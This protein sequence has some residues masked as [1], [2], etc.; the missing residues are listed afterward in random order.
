[1]ISL[2][3][4]SKHEHGTYVA[5]HLSK[6]S[7]TEL[8]NYIKLNFDLKERLDKTEYH[9]T[10]IYSKT[11]VPSAESLE[12]DISYG[13]DGEMNMKNIVQL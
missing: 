8:D 12:R 11:P 1:M 5:A 7:Q 2:K 13:Y 3:E 10:I 4:H 9:T 6:D